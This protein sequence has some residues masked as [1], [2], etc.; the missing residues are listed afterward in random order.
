MDEA[1]STSM[2]SNCSHRAGREKL[3]PKITIPGPCALQLRGGDAAVLAGACKDL[4]EFWDDTVKAFGGELAGAG[5]RW[6]HSII[7]SMRRPSP[8]SVIRPCRRS[9]RARGDRLERADRQIYRRHQP[10]SRERA[11][12]IRIGMHLCRGNRGG[13]WHAEGGYDLVADELF[14]ALDIDFF[15]LNTTRRGPA[16]SRRCAWCRRERPSRSDWC[17]PRRRR[18][19]TR[20]RSSGAVEEAGRHVDLDALALEKLN[21]GF[22]SSEEGNPMPAG[23]ARGE[24]SAGGRCRT[25]GLGRKLTVAADPGEAH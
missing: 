8:S 13:H 2:I 24:T 7:R 12:G 1:R 23:C 10:H 19:R 17:R 3:I 20:P 16:I 18:W 15:F 11:D 6:L 22:A 14:N 5:R 21:V 9:L 4:D 25:G